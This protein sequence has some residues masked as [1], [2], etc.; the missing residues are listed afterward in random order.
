MRSPATDYVGSNY[1][2][3]AESKRLTYAA[4]A[5]VPC[6]FWDDNEISAIRCW[7]G[8]KSYLLIGLDNHESDATVQKYRENFPEA[9]GVRMEGFDEAHSELVRAGKAA[10]LPTPSQ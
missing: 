7:I 4:I 3:V 8:D 9:K 5:V 10:W 6:Q 1:Q 2:I